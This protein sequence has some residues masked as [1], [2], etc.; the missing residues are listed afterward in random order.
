[1]KPIDQ[2]CAFIAL[3]AYWSSSFLTAKYTSLHYT[4]RRAWHR[5]KKDQ[6]AHKAIIVHIWADPQLI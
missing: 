3:S 2:I 4:I 1:M 6:Y 5:E